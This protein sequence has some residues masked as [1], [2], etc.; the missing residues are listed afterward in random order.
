VA[1]RTDPDYD[2]NM[3]M[4]AAKSNPSL[5]VK[6]KLENLTISSNEK[7]DQYLR[8]IRKLKEKRANKK[9]DLMKKNINQA[10]NWRSVSPVHLLE[11]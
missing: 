8:Q 5:V 7:K 2:Y 1:R 3:M 6:L 9:L 11:N 4:Q 10:K